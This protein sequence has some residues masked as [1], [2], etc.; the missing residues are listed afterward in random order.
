MG[1]GLSRSLL[2]AALVAAFGLGSVGMSAGCA[3]QQATAPT[4]DPIGPGRGRRKTSERVSGA[5]AHKRAASKRRCARARACTRVEAGCAMSVR[6]DESTQR[7]AVDVPA[8]KVLVPADE[9]LASLPEGALL[10][11]YLKKRGTETPRGLKL[12][13]A[14]KRRIIEAAYLAA[15]RVQN[16]PAEIKDLFWVVHG[17]ALP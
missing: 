9:A 15:R 7:L 10:A 11:A 5:A 3:A 8:H 16:L 6:F 13:P 17:R 14:E 2:G 12:M 4:P 1:M